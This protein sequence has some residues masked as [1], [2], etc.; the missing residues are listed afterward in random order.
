MI[1]IALCVA[2]LILMAYYY[3][4]SAGIKQAKDDCEACMNEAMMHGAGSALKKLSLIATWRKRL[5]R[6]RGW[7]D[8]WLI[9]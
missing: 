9:D 5:E 7:L 6:P 4:K 1:P 2:V 8:R 3:G